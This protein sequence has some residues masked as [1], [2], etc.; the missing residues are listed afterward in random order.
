MPIAKV[1]FLWLLLVFYRAK[2]L[3]AASQSTQSKISF[4]NVKIFQACKTSNHYCI[5][6]PPSSQSKYIYFNAVL[7]KA[8]INFDCNKLSYKITSSTKLYNGLQGLGQGKNAFCALKTLDT[9]G[10]CQI[11]V[12]TVGA[13][14]H[15]RIYQSCEKLSSI[16]RRSCEMLM[17]EKNTFVAP[18]SH[19]VVCAFRCLISRP[20]I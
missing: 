3:P 11:L 19:E 10:N 2:G 13:S 15:I 4:L 18:W 14:Q 16:G 6:P 17:K 9:I 20:Q 1:A 8:T 12:F 7:G 5:P